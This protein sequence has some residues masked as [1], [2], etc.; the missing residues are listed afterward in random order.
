MNAFKMFQIALV[1]TVL[2][3]MTGCSDQITSSGNP[4]SVS[5]ASHGVMSASTENRDKP[6][7]KT[8]IRIK[9]NR[10]YTFRHDNT[11]FASIN[12]IKVD[13]LNEINDSESGNCSNFQITGKNNFE[14][15]QLSCESKGFNVNEIS[16]QNLT[17]KFLDLEVTLDGVKGNK[18]P[19]IE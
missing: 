1:I 13:L 15:S 19:V 5:P 9:P 8:Q 3:F 2:T 10:S 18:S 17:N 16:I 14:K 7:F 4:E 12:Y 11:G 6:V